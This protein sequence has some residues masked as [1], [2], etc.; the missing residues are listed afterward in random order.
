MPDIETALATISEDESQ[1]AKDFPP[2]IDRDTVALPEDKGPRALILRQMDFTGQLGE[3]RLAH[4]TQVDVDSDFTVGRRHR[5]SCRLSPPGPC[6]KMMCSWADR[7]RD[8]ALRLQSSVRL[9]IYE[10]LDWNRAPLKLDLRKTI[11]H[12]PP[13]AD[14]PQ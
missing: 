7:N 12:E 1:L 11:E 4:P 14:A 3:Y 2:V 10:Y 8:H 13:G 9:P 6:L 5:R